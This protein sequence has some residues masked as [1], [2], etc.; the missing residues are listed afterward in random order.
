MGVWIINFPRLPQYKGSQ[1]ANMGPGFAL[2]NLSGQ[3]SSFYSHLSRGQ[4]S[5]TKRKSEWGG[6]Y[7]KFSCKLQCQNM[8][9]VT[10]LQTKYIN[11]QNIKSKYFDSLEKDFNMCLWFQSDKW[12]NIY[13]VRHLWNIRKW[14]KTWIG[15]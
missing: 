5:N 6:K 14:Y 10:A 8:K 4:G 11:N 9:T 3:R 12:M 1:T 2:W 13:N 15:W 7:L